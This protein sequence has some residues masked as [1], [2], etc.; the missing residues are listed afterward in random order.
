VITVSRRSK[1]KKAFFS[2]QKDFFP[3]EYARNLFCI[4]KTSFS[5]S[6]RANSFP[7]PLKYDAGSTGLSSPPILP[8]RMLS[9]FHVGFDVVYALF[10]V[11][12]EA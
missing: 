4:M 2:C 1:S 3:E 6:E 7:L 8:C 11:S 9:F 5:Q 12:S 10:R